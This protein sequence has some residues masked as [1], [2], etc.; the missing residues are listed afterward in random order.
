MGKLCVILYDQLSDDL[1]SL[2]T[3]KA[4]EDTVLICEDWAFLQKI[5]HH[6]KKIV[7]MMS[8]ARHYA[9]SLRK[10]GY[11]VIHIP[12]TQKKSTTQAVSDCLNDQQIESIVLT[13]PN[14][15]S[16]FVETSTWSK[17]FKKPVEILDDDRFFC[18]IDEFKQWAAN[19]K[20]L[21]ME[22]FYR[23]M[24]KTH[25]VLMDGD[26]PVGGKWNY[27]HSNRK[28]P[29]ES[30]QIPSPFEQKVDH[31]TQQVIEEVEAHFSHHFGDILPFFLAVTAQQAQQALERFINERLASFGDYQD[32]MIEGEPFMYHAHLSGY[33]N[34]GI[35][36]AKHAVE[37]VLR[38]YDLGHAPLNAVEGFIRQILG[39]REYV[40]GIYWLKMPEYQTMNALKAQ[41]PLPQ[42]FWSA[43]T[44]MNCMHH[45]I[46]QT[47]EH[48]YAHHI[49]R[50]MVLG[51]F[52]LLTGLH[53]DEVN[54]WYHIVYIDAYH[55]VELP[56]VSGM[57]LFADG[58]VLASKPYASGGNYINK[59]SDY[60][61]NC[62]YNVQEKTGDNACPFNY[63]YWDFLMRHEQVLHQ[64]PRIAMMYR[65][66]SKMSD[67][68][69]QQ[70]KDSTN[71][72]FKTF[73]GDK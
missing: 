73:E 71:T 60:C 10:K 11:Q 22:Y 30:M 69:K 67:E 52:A 5:Q 7:F 24:R 20:Q 68:K 21:R 6:Q 61:Q 46:K 70:I 64:N 48:A 56:N 35:L 16:L 63:L 44:T 45:C 40:R 31:I 28:P 3:I 51:N 41:R 15:Y 42:F 36:S 9:Q 43:E 65:T 59:M 4:S 12:F 25:H 23:E 47:K 33:F 1:S 72:F 39:W 37:S 34:V 19:R 2:Q 8:C 50:L 13:H 49:Q 32:A 58:G 54:E 17:Q 18:R 62:H 29:R 26:V 53:P 38:A 66:L 57:I 55:W 14:D 27:D